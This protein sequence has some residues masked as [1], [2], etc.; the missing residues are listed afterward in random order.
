MKNEGDKKWCELY[1]GESLQWGREK[2]FRRR[3]NHE[4]Q[5]GGGGSVYTHYKGNGFKATQE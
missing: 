2:T 4:I 5:M 1:M 3:M